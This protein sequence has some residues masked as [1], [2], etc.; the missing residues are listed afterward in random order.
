MWVRMR[1]ID[2]VSVMKATMRISAPQWGQARGRVTNGARAAWPLD[3]CG[4]FFCP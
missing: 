1:S 3:P 4:L 2:A